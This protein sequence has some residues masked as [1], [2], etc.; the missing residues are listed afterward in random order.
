MN[1][2]RPL[3]LA[4]LATLLLAL[5][6]V[7]PAS[8]GGPTASG[9]VVDN[10]GAPSSDPRS[11]ILC[12]SKN[13]CKGTPVVCNTATG[14]G[15]WNGN[16]NYYRKTFP[17]CESPYIYLTANINVC[18]VGYEE[19]RLYGTV[20][21]PVKLATLS[22]V[23]L[24][25]YCRAQNY[26][27]IRT[28]FPN[29]MD[30]AAGIPKAGTVWASANFTPDV[31]QMGEE[32]SLSDY[33]TVAKASTPNCAS[34]AL[35]PRVRTDN[36]KVVS[37]SCDQ[38]ETTGGNTVG[39]VLTNKNTSEAIKQQLRER[40][41][42]Q[43]KTAK[44]NPSYYTNALAASLSGQPVNGLSA[45][46]ITSA[47]AIT[48][49]S[50]DHHCSSPL[51]FIPA[52]RDKNATVDPVIIGAC[53]IPLFLPARVLQDKSQ[54][55]TLP[56]GSANPD[57]T[58]YGFWGNWNENYV[59][60]FTQSPGRSVNTS[61]VLDPTIG[62][63]IDPSKQY[64]DAIRTLIKNDPGVLEVDGERRIP[65]AYFYPRSIST[66]NGI[67]AL[68]QAPD[69]AL[70]EKTRT[71]RNL[72]ANSAIAAASC[73]SM[74]LAPYLL[75]CT[76]S[77]DACEPP[78]I[79]T[80]N[81]GDPICT[82][83]CGDPICTQ[84]C[85][86]PICTQNCS[87]T[88]RPEGDTSGPVKVVVNVNAPAAYTVGGLS[89]LQNT[90]VSS[91][92]ILCN[93]HTCG[94][95]PGDATVTTPQGSLE[96]GAVNGYLACSSPSQTKC[97]LY[98]TKPSGVGPIASRNNTSVY[99]SPTRS[100]ESVQVYVDN[101][102]AV[103]T[104]KVWIPPREVNCTA[105]ATELNPD[106]TPCSRTIPGYWKDDIDGRYTITAFVLRFTDG[107]SGL[108]KVTGTIGK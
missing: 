26:D 51:D 17:K 76:D 102:S 9:G 27:L 43:Y 52:L 73:W 72:I 6:P 30:S 70:A 32:V 39:A 80:K 96:L 50:S 11:T 4:L 46:A 61:S 86:D 29:P 63:Q 108:R 75:D 3:I 25:N 47:S 93:G 95:Q 53:T 81:C 36:T 69:Q 94:S 71:D 67:E 106:P 92:Q 44:R 5:I 56:D 15:S 38:F 37:G 84:N 34:S 87:T 91:I 78:P 23:N 90:A 8:A 41:F 89:R 59:K 21:D 99:F 31:T 2:R 97:G 22:R 12:T 60:R 24:P 62:T 19:I 54:P 58:K 105:P 7:Q 98:T 1:T 45:P 74:Q 104:P 28:Y 49:Y 103:V 57:H 79:C 64:T 107:K 48:G 33:C 16:L 88:P 10:G 83:N 101:A 20:S 55:A 100:S 14:G 66:K 18:L 82:Q 42:T 65:G 85:G 40:I 77:A 35:R 68:I 13:G